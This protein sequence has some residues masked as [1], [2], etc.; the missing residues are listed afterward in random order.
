MKLSVRNMEWLARIATVLVVCV[1]IT[2]MIT[3]PFFNVWWMFSQMLIYA[4]SGLI[5][6]FISWAGGMCVPTPEE[7]T[8]VLLKYLVFFL[9]FGYIWLAFMA[10]S[11]FWFRNIPRSPK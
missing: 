8:H 9:I 10:T 4:C 7:K 6:F 1:I 2:A 5:T 3:L 11:S